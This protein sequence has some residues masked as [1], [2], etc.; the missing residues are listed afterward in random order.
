MHASIVVVPI[1]VPG[2]S[3]VVGRRRRQHVLVVPRG[4]IDPGRVLVEKE[5]GGEHEVRRDEHEAL[6]PV[7]PAV[8]H[9]RGG[10]W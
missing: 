3:S 1:V 5:G 2:G 8:G 9:D 6:E 4:A 10:A 7:A